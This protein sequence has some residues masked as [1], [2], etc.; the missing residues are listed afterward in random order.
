ML[1]KIRAKTLKSIQAAASIGDSENIQNETAR[2]AQID[3]LIAQQSALDNEIAA[4]QGGEIPPSEKPGVF[5][6]ARSRKEGE[7]SP[8]AQGARRRSD[9]VHDC[10]KRGITLN[11][12][13]GSLFKNPKGEQV[14]IASASERKDNAWFL[15]LP[16][17]EFKHAV[18][19]C[20]NKQDRIFA[21]CLAKSF[22][23]Q[24][25]KNLS[26]SKNQT[27]FNVALRHGN[28]FLSV[29]SIGPVPIDQYINQPKLIA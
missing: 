14:G 5:P 11:H 1:Q 12:V 15:G 13:K 7:L 9:F 16:A 21:V 6:E 2:L 23:D 29:P 27:K 10:A 3:S 20:E 24:Y 22:L 25:G 8:R 18:L 26:E 19:L 17:N 4:L 28:Y